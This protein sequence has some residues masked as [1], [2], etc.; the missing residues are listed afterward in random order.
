[1]E[2]IRLIVSISNRDL[3]SVSAFAAVEKI[4]PISRWML[5]RRKRSIIVDASDVWGIQG[6]VLI[7]AF[8]ARFEGLNVFAPAVFELRRKYGSELYSSHFMDAIA[9]RKDVVD[10]LLSQ[11]CYA[12]D[13]TAVRTMLRHG[14]DPNRVLARSDASVMRVCGS[15]VRELILAGG[16]PSV[17]IGE[18]CEAHTMPGD[19]R[20]ERPC[21]R[22]ES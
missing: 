1:M 15:V 20:E 12:C 19:G 7:A 3:E 11:H 4:G 17:F 6:A 2:L 5:R 21:P 9:G 10:W 14:A 16:T 8:C 13:V 22:R 18:Q